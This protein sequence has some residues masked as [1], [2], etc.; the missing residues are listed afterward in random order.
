MIVLID[1]NLR[2]NLFPF[3]YTRH[4]ANIR[5]GIFTIKEKWELLLNEK[6]SFDETKDGLHIPSNIIPTKSNYKSIIAA[7]NE[8]LLLIESHEIKIIKYPWQIFQYN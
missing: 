6:V 7:A 8:N 3:T 4:T 1:N 5:I 2:E